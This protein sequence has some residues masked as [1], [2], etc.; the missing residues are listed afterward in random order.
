MVGMSLYYF[1]VRDYSNEPSSG[2]FGSDSSRILILRAGLYGF[3]RTRSDRLPPLSTPQPQF[4]ICG[5]V[6]LGIEM[7]TLPDPRSVHVSGTVCTGRVYPHW[8]SPI[9]W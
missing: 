9:F 5:D 4:N 2:P 3:S 6:R 8:T 1:D 7:S